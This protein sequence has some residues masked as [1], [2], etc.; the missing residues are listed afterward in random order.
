M[1]FLMDKPKPNCLY[2]GSLDRF[3]PVSPSLYKAFFLLDLPFVPGLFF[4]KNQF[5]FRV[6]NSFLDFTVIVQAST[7]FTVVCFAANSLQYCTV[8]R[9]QVR[10]EIAK[11]GK[12]G[13]GPEF[14]WALQPGAISHRPA[15]RRQRLT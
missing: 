10:L 15:A 7:R 9:G 2:I 1:G 6:G 11:K 8:L 3:Y 12:I 14:G 13:R 4:F 5:I